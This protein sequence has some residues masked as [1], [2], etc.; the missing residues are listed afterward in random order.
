MRRRSVNLLALALALALA[1]AVA[2]GVGVAACNGGDDGEGLPGAPMELRAVFDASSGVKL[3]WSDVSDAEDKFLV[4][5]KVADSNDKFF[6]LAELPADTVEY[7]DT[8]VESGTIYRYRV[9]AVNGF[10]E[11]PSEDVLIMVP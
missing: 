6:V 11:S 2:L 1:P 9:L 3:S 4:E 10:G 5:R 8:E 7:V